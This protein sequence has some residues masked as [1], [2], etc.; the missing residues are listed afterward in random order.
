MHFWWRQAW[1]TATQNVTDGLMLH[2]I[3]E[4][5]VCQANVASALRAAHGFADHK[6]SF[7]PAIVDSK[8]FACAEP[9]PPCARCIGFFS[10][11]Q[12]W[13][14]NVTRDFPV[15]ATRWYIVADSTRVQEVEDYGRPNEHVPAPNRGRGFLWRLD[16]IPGMRSARRQCRD[17][18]FSS[19]VNSLRRTSNSAKRKSSLPFPC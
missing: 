5:F 6:R 10:L 18:E 15:N 4:A 11:P 2:W 9:D 12:C 8:L 16:K 19:L 17:F 3:A 1:G 13:T 14:A 7:Q